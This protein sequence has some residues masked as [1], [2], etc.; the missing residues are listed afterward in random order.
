MPLAELGYESEDLGTDRDLQETV[1]ILR[2]AKQELL[3][4]RGKQ[5][6]LPTSASKGSVDLG[7]R[8]HR[9][10]GPNLLRR[11]LAHSLGAGF[12]DVELDQN[13]GIDEQ[14]QRRSSSTISD[15]S[16]PWFGSAAR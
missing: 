16:L 9:G 5:E 2:E 14:D 4:L 3:K 6:R 12:R 13:A 11:R 10:A 7:E 15:A 1:P 8:E